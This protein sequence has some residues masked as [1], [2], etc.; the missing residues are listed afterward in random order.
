[1][2]DK[3]SGRFA[4]IQ[5]ARD[6]KE[7]LLYGHGGES[8]F[9]Y[10]AQIDELRWDKN[11]PFQLLMVKHTGGGRY[12][13]IPFGTFTLPIGPQSL[14]KS[15]PFAISGQVTQG[16]YNEEH[17]G[18]PVRPISLS[19]TTGVFPGRGTSPTLGQFNLGQSI[20]AGTIRSAQQTASTATGLQQNSGFTSN[21]VTDTELLGELKGTTGYAQFLM[22]QQFFEVYA[23]LKKQSINKDLRLAFAH[24]KTQ[25]VY[26]VTPIDFNVSQSVGS[27]LKYT[28][29][30]SMKAWRRID[31][32]AVEPPASVVRPVSREPGKL[33]KSLASID[34]ARR[35]LA[36]L[37]DVIRSAGQDVDTVL[38]EPLRSTALMLKDSLGIPVSAADLP[39]NIVRDMK[40]A[41]LEA[42]GIP[43]AVNDTANAYKNLGH[44]LGSELADIDTK[45]KY[46]AV[47]TG[48]AETGSGQSPN[49]LGTKQQELGGADPAAKILE[50]PQDNYALF[51]KIKP[52]NMNLAP[53]TTRKIKDERERVRRLTRL[54]FENMRDGM[55]ALSAAFADAVGAGGDTYNRVYNRN[56]VVSNKTPTQDDFDA[57][58]AMNNAIMEMDRLAASGDVGDRTK[59]NAIEYVAGL[60][61][62]SGIN[63]KIPASKISVPFPYGTTLERLAA[64]YLGD[65]DRWHE[66]ATLNNLREPYVDE[67]GFDLPLLVNGTQNT[68]WV[69]DASNLFVGQPLW[70][71]SSVV[72]REKRRITAIDVVSDGSV[73]LT[74][75][76]EPD[77]GRFTVQATATVHAYLPGTVNS[78]MLIFIPSDVAPALEDFEGRAIPGLDEFNNLLHVGGVDLLLTQNGDAA[79]TPDGDWKLAV[80]MA[81]L[82]QY[83]RTFCATPAGSMIQHPDWGLGLKPGM[84]TADAS[85]NDILAGLQQLR[86]FNP[87]F[88]AIRGATVI[89][90]GPVLTI[91]AALEVAGSSQLLPIS[92]DVKL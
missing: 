40:G 70:I 85:A 71:A 49:R 57:M 11:Y 74:L 24:W 68:I 91:G 31:L 18:T 65:P 42:A 1:M 52:G 35:V 84:S 4:S 90:D 10:T 17:N 54:D 82:V 25:E 69:S 9:W 77:L 87:V 13:P 88:T 30:L 36:G 14:S 61:G 66:I 92:I 33:Q 51:E 86:A 6:N 60:A 28:Y 15:M 56:A 5:L 41:I 16:G 72:S 81:N 21:L 2:A 44:N 12:S 83:V 47:S 19:G 22:L 73:R 76:G 39:I 29:S 62:Q 32:K 45:L 89:K 38:F 64:R 34:A 37:K 48:K 20:F 53:A 79:I 27:P 67:V 55:V 26:L 80:G 50:N 58:F 43:V 46:L 3:F 23:N 78:Q 59:L 63:F 75:D 7:A 8:P